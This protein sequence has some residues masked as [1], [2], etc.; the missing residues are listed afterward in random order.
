MVVSTTYLV[1]MAPSRFSSFRG[2]YSRP[3]PGQRLRHMASL[4]SASTTTSLQQFVALPYDQMAQADPPI[5][6][7]PPRNPLRLSRRPSNINT[8]TT[9]T[10]VVVAPWTTPCGPDWKRD[11]CQSRWSLS[12]SDA[13]E[14]RPAPKD[15]KTTTTTRNLVRGLSLRLAPPMRRTKKRSRGDQGSPARP[16]LSTSPNGAPP[17]PKPE[18]PTTKQS[19][20]DPGPLSDNV[21]SPSVSAPT[22]N[23]DI[24]HASFLD[25]D[26]LD[27]INFS[28]RG[29]VYFG[30]NRAISAPIPI[31]ATAPMGSFSD[32]RAAPPAPPYRQTNGPSDRAPA[33]S[34]APSHAKTPSLPDIR[35]M[36][37]DT[38][39]ES[40]KVRSLYES[41]DLIDWRDGAPPR[42]HAEP[43]DSPVELV[44]G[45]QDNTAYDFP[46]V[47]Y[48]FRPTLWRLRR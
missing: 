17:A 45:A 35:V 9:N 39:R 46:S 48:F 3:Y 43:R 36:S 21:L 42:H 5:P 40:Q 10:T 38:E 19:P 32:P 26:L 27:S 14:P 47:F 11:S 20:A 4:D 6:I 12:D 34:R 41:G 16:Q 13:S 2:S 23:T 33:P 28:N 8:A 37:V 15:D 24:P 31:L 25:D 18:S 7:P 22:I 1:K 30:G 29:S 44:S